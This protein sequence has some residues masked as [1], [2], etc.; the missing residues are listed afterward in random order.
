MKLTIAV[1]AL[2]ALGAGAGIGPAQAADIKTIG[3]VGEGVPPEMRK[4]MVDGAGQLAGREDPASP[5]LARNAIRAASL[6]CQKK[7]GWSAD[8]TDAAEVAATADLSYQGGLAKAVKAGISERAIGAAL[9]TLTPE[10][11]AAILGSDT[12]AAMEAFAATLTAHGIDVE[13]EG[14][15]ELIVVLTVF[16]IYGDQSRQTFAAS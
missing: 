12:D 1:I 15:L 14:N 3:C 9:G 5:A 2:A 16:K 4:L 11:R 8:A 13:K 10:Q 6:A 7:H